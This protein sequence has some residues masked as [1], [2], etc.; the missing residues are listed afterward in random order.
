MPRHPAQTRSAENTVPLPAQVIRPVVRIAEP[1]LPQPMAGS[2]RAERPPAPE[3]TEQPPTIQVT[4]GR[5]EVRATPAPTAPAPGR[6]AAP[7]MTLE[8]YLR[9]RSNGGSR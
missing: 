6:R 8:E 5:I 1:N 3:A 2:P 9:Q 7:I 4:I